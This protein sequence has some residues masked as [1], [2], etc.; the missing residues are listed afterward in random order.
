M[1]AIDRDDLRRRW[2]AL[3]ARLR[4][5]PDRAPNLDPLLAA[6]E[7]PHR[8][9]HNLRH[10][11]QML[12]EFD[13]MRDQC[14]APDTVELAIWYHDAVYESTRNDNE[15]QSAA[16]A[17]NDL[18]TA[19]LPDETIEAVVDLILATKHSSAPTTRDAR[20]LIDIDLS[21]LGQPAQAF[22]EYERG[23][24]REYAHVD[25]QAFRAG[26]AAILERFL[27]RRNIFST[28]QM[29][30]KYEASAG[31]NIRR[32]IAQ[33]RGPKPPCRDTGF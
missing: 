33:L 3:W 20:V 2:N 26:R 5:S 18:R 7:E 4:G 22:D 30:E 15:E 6:Y 29:R 13:A 27:A 28:V 12:H 11:S 19:G 9:Y 32:S 25:E 14:D 24:R 8:A 23:I 10:I 31:Q 16:L 17:G 1:T 21:I